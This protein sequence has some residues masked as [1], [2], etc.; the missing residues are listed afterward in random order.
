MFVKMVAKLI[1]GK[2]VMLGIVRCE[3]IKIL[4]DLERVIVL[5]CSVILDSNSIVMG[6]SLIVIVL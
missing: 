6:V 5:R 3:F 4:C 2:A 1:Y